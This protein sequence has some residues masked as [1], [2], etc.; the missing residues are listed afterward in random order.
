MGPDVPSILYS[1]INEI[2]KDRIRADVFSNVALSQT[3]CEE[4]LK[5]CKA[6]L[7]KRASSEEMATI[8]EGLLHY[9]LTASML[10]SQRKSVL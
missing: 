9:M 4:I 8:C 5:R 2:G 3:H 6:K 1:V 10:P 7:G